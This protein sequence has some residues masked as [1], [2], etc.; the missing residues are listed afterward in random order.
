CREGG[1]SFPCGSS[2]ATHWHIHT[3]EKPYKCPECGKSFGRSSKLS[4]HQR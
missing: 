2:L 1:R 4:A 3:G